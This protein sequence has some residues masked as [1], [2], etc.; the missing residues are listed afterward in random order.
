[1][2]EAGRGLEIE[3]SVIG[4]TWYNNGGHVIVVWLT[5]NMASKLTR[6]NFFTSMANL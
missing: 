1:V 6:S 5:S 4:A 2:N 3:S